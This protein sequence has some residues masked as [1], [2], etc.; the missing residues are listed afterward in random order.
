METS[1]TDIDSGLESKKSDE[2]N[3][4][5]QKLEE[6]PRSHTQN[7]LTPITKTTNKLN[8]HIGKF[9]SEILTANV[10]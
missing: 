6:T 9:E 7:N 8:T 5:R 10:Q 1:T 4:K 3:S 2:S